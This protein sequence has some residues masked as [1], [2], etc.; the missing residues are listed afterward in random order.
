LLLALAKRR[1]F[2]P[3][4][5]QPVFE[6]WISRDFLQAGAGIALKRFLHAEIL[7]VVVLGI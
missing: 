1:G 6:L 7:A 4:S 2:L 5:S 3:A